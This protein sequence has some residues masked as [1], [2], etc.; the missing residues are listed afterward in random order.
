[1]NLRNSVVAVALLSAASS[2]VCA[3]YIDGFMGAIF[4]FFLVPVWL[5]VVLVALGL[6]GSGTFENQSHA[7]AYRVF[8]WVLA[9][10]PFFMVAR[11]NDQ[12]SM[13]IVSLVGGGALILVLHL[14]RR[15]Q[16]STESSAQ[17]SE[18]EP[19]Q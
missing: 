9:L 2:P 18:S 17:Q 11:S 5:V 8:A 15:T 19:P 16:T 1:M 12:V 10:V 3:S 13:G 7:Y 4:V 14:T 6:R